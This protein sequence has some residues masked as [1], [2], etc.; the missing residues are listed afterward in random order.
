MEAVNQPMRV[1]NPGLGWSLIQRAFVVDAAGHR[2]ASVA[3]NAVVL[4]F[5]GATGV[6]STREGDREMVSSDL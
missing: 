5:A 6:L 4:E 2:Q 3:V 1:V